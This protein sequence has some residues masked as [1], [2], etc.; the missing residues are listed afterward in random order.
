MGSNKEC[1]NINV[2]LRNVYLIKKE[3]KMMLCR[4]LNPGQLHDKQLSLPLDHAVHP[5]IVLSCKVIIDVEIT[6]VIGNFSPN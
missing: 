2:Q 4:G 1:P 6:A 3:K 5:S